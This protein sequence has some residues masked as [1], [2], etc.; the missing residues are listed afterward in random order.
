MPRTDLP[1]PTDAEL[2]ILRSLWDLG[3][4]TVRDVHTS[5]ERRR[6]I[7]YTTVLKL[8]QIMAAKGLVER[9][10]T[11]R[12]HVYQA[13]VAR[14]HTQRQMVGHLMD[15]AFGGSAAKLMMQ[16]LSGRKASKE[17]IAQ[18][19]QMLADFEKGKEPQR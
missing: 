13:K 16:A 4:S 9:D 19:R 5:L 14:E 2:E 11:A 1:R 6:E 15:R 3:P 10:E 17:E 7:G 12:A 8:L 18:M